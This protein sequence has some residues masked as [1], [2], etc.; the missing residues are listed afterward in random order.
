MN[1][2]WLL[3]TINTRNLGGWRVGD[4]TV[5]YTYAILYLRKALKYVQERE[6]EEKELISKYLDLSGIDNWMVLL[7]EWKLDNKVRGITDFQ[8]RRFVKSIK[9]RKEV[10]YDRQA[11]D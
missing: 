4:K 3:Y 2:E 9:N 7:S 5:D 11:V 10:K 6:I 8:A 1:S